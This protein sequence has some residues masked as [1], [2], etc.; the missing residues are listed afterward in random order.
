MTF[1]AL[2]IYTT[3]TWNMA[4]DAER[5]G[6]IVRAKTEFIGYGKKIQ[7]KL[8]P[9]MVKPGSIGNTNTLGM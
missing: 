8:K 9:F 1:I 3:V 4:I 2:I 7:K 5:S 6:D